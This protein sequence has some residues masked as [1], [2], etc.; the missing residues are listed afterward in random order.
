MGML[1]LGT[2]TDWDECC[3]LGAVEWLPKG[4]S[5]VLVPRGTCQGPKA[6][7]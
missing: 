7:C 2:H 6:D 5:C 3:E 4:H 1:P